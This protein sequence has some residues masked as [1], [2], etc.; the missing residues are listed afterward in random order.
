MYTKHALSATLLSTLTLAQS[1]NF[2]IDPT[3]SSKVVADVEHFITTLTA[4]PTFQTDVAVLLSAVPASV[5]LEASNDPAALLEELSNEED[6]PAWVSA[7][8][9]SVIASLETLAAKPIEAVEDVTLYI[10]ELAGDPEV[11]SVI[12]V[13]ATA[14]PSSVQ[15]EI[16]ADPSAFLESIVTATALPSWVSGIPA[17]LQSKIG[18]V[19]NQGL[20]IIAADLEGST[21]TVTAKVGTAGAVVPTYTAVSGGLTSVVSAQATGSGAGAGGNG[22]IATGSPVPI[23]APASG[24]ASLRVAAGS[25]VALVAAGAGFW[26]VG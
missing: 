24:A 13:L 26:F 7:I 9:T 20:S 2:N 17:P 12:S 4:N 21:A 16:D 10:E 11:E 22:S 5:L 25:V 19:I 15:E 1:N 6:L 14:V 3:A 18:S 23:Q 8:P